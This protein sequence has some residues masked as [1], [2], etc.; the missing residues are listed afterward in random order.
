MNQ[1]LEPS[2]FSLAA[3]APALPREQPLSMP[4][5][6]LWQEFA[7]SRSRPGGLRRRSATTLLTR[8][9]ILAFTIA[10]TVVFAWGLHQA[11]TSVTTAVPQTVLILL[12][13]LCFAWVAF[14]SAVAIAGTIGILVRGGYDSISL[15]EGAPPLARRTALL[16]PVYHEDPERIAAVIEAIAEQLW[17]LGRADAFDFF[18]LSDSRTAQSRDLER[19]VFSALN[20]AVAADR[21]VYYRNRQNNVGKKAG[22]VRDWIIRF[23]RG[24]DHFVIL[25]ADSVMS[26]RTL[27]QLASAMERNDDAGLIQTAPRLVGGET[28]FARLQQFATGYYGPLAATG[29]AMFQGADGNYWGHNAII[30]TRAFAESAGL[31]KL[32][33]SAPLGG[34]IQSH[35]FVEAAL[36]RRS[37]WDVHL[38]TSMRGSYEGCPPTL[39]EMSTRDR[40]WMQ[41]NIQHSRIVAANGLPLFSRLHLTLG[42]FAYVASGLWAAALLIGLWLTYSARASTP[43][44]FPKWETLF[45]V[46]PTYNPEAALLVLL[47][48]LAVVFMPKF[49]GLV[50]ALSD[51]RAMR[52]P[53]KVLLVFGWLVEV[54]MSTLLAP[55]LMLN[56]LRALWEIFRGR[57]S[58]WAAQQRD[59]HSVSFIAS[60][61][62]HCWHV[63]TGLAFALF[64]L[65]IS[66]HVALWMSPILMGLILSPLLTWWT[67]RLSGPLLSALLATDEDRTP[68]A[69]VEAALGRHRQ[70]G[71][72]QRNFGLQP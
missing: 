25:D 28:V 56:Q 44:Y 52:L 3:A 70:K 49:L 27:V 50:L 15:P 33:G 55:V 17:A 58:G 32:P 40:R 43:E 5:Q 18:V 54:V 26:G 41:G 6:R 36:L 29:Y 46:W 35:D 22:N 30:R 39:I 37:G 20:Q 71:R 31:P 51:R 38:V 9:G 61:R 23:G 12:S 8:A 21:P 66:P 13:S 10:A 57:D 19:R 11:L 24:Y 42:V 72:Y 63:T 7:G 59:G 16:F 14:G 1:R 68:P 2:E 69:V 45:P 65:H 47:A 67:S 64:A 48:T 53:Q 4:V 34:H 62:Y 60:L